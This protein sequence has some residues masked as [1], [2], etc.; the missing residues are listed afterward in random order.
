MALWWPVGWHTL[1]TGRDKQGDKHTGTNRETFKYGQ[2]LVF[3]PVCTH[4]LR[5]GRTGRQKKNINMV[6]GLILAWERV[7][8]PGKLSISRNSVQSNLLSG[9]VDQS[10]HC[11]WCSPYYLVCNI[12]GIYFWTIFL[13]GQLTLWCKSISWVSVKINRCCKIEFYFVGWLL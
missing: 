8:H 7:V 2:R 3:Y 12:T 1:P 6:K 13:V 11:D 4:C 5:P 10:G 9:G